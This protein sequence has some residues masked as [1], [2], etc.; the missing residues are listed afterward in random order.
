MVAVTK[1]FLPLLK[2]SKGRI[3]NVSS[4]AGRTCNPFLMSYCISKYGVEAFSDSLRLEMKIWNVSV[5]IIEPGLFKTEAV[6]SCHDQL[7]RYAANRL[8]ELEQRTIDEY[9]EQYL[10]EGE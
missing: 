9:G 4:G 2:K 1:T 5:H 3:V 6:L 10:Q 7:L 8:K